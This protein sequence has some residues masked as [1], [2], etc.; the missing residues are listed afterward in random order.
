[1][2]QDQKHVAKDLV[3]NYFD[4]FSTSEFDVGKTYLMVHEIDTGNN[5]P[6]KHQLRRHP[7][8]HLDIIDKHVEEMVKQ[9]VVSPCISPY[10]SNVV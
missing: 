3:E 4:V 6:F 10:S 7:K 5:P 1:M 2:T 9:G 8:A